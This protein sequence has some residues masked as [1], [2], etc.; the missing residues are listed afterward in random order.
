MEKSH[1]GDQCWLVFKPEEDIAP[2]FFLVCKHLD[3][4][5][6]R[7]S[8][9]R[10]PKSENLG[11]FRFLLS[12]INRTLKNIERKRTKYFS[13]CFLLAGAFSLFKGTLSQMS[14][15]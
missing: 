6:Y 7:M 8:S 2:S 3:Q 15:F 13:K 4:Q 11:T 12:M 14:I 10:G 1:H 5:R 9:I